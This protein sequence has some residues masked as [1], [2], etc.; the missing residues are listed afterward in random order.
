VVV[1]GILAE[2]R[3]VGIYIVAS[4]GA[5]TILFLYDAITLAG[6]SLFAGIYASGDR[7]ELQRF[8]T[9]AC[10]AVLWGTLPVFL[11]LFA[12]APWFLSLFGAEFIEGQDVFRVLLTTYFVSSLGGFVIIMLYMTGHQRDVAAVMGVLALVN[13]AG[14]AVLIRSMGMMGAALASG[15]TLVLL[16]FT[17]VAL[18]HRRTGILSLPFRPPRWLPRLQPSLPP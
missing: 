1:L 15:A 11:V 10:K 14:S 4:R 12:A 2:S 9:L 17:L 3:E 8:T 13:I 6:A 7:V 18:L 16:K 5:E